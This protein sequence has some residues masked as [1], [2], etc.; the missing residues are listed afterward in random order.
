M[1]K[2]MRGDIRK[3]QEGCECQDDE[4]NYPA[5]TEICLHSCPMGDEWLP[6]CDNHVDE[7]KQIVDSTVIEHDSTDDQMMQF[8]HDEMI[9]RLFGGDEPDSVDDQYS[10]TD[11]HPLGIFCDTLLTGFVLDYN[12]VPAIAQCSQHFNLNGPYFDPRYPR[13]IGFSAHW[14]G[15]AVTVAV[16]LD[17]MVAKWESKESLNKLKLGALANLVNRIRSWGYPIVGAELAGL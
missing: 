14:V 6:I 9:D 13:W 15:N 1:S 10:Y 4:C 11:R 17:T 12:D 3:L 5:T 2:S 7:Y 16:N 8:E